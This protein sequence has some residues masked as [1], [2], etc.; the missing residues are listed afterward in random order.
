MDKEELTLIANT[1]RNR[2]ERGKMALG[3]GIFPLLNA[4]NGKNFDYVTSRYLL[5]RLQDA[6]TLSPM[7]DYDLVAWRKLPHIEKKDGHFRLRFRALFLKDGE[8]VY[9]FTVVKEGDKAFDVVADSHLYAKTQMLEGNG[10]CYVWDRGLYVNTHM[11]RIFTMDFMENNHIHDIEALMRY[12][13]EAW[14]V[15]VHN[16][17]SKPAEEEIIAAAV[18][19][20]RKHNEKSNAA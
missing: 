8:Q 4:D 3:E 12:K 2:I 17:I 15:F 1:F 7:V 6:L 18:E 10:Y 14:G 11:K 9:P 5:T 20:A 16:A 13:S 19:Y